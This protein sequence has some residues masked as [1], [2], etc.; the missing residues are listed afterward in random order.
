MAGDVHN[1]AP[2]GLR[3]LAPLGHRLAALLTGPAGCAFI[4]DLG[5]PRL[6]QPLPAT[7][8]PSDSFG[9]Q[10][11]RRTEI[12]LEFDPG[13]DPI[14]GSLREGKGVRRPF[15]GWLGLAAALEAALRGDRESANGR[16][17][18]RR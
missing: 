16:K 5:R 9:R 14:S 1:A 6:V 17:H 10:G 7:A 12:T 18:Q 3:Q 8:S 11:R 15:A 4:D 13:A 2:R